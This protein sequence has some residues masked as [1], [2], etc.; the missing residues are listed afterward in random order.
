MSTSIFAPQRRIPPPS[1]AQRALRPRRKSVARFE[2]IEIQQW[3]K[4]W[5]IACCT[6]RSTTVGIPS[7]RV[8]P[9]ASVSP[10][11][12][13]AGARSS[14]QQCGHQFFD[15][16]PGSLHTALPPSSHRCPYAPL[17]A[18]AFV[19]PAQVLL[20][21]HPFHQIVRQG[22]ALGLACRDCLPL[23]ARLRLVP[24]SP[25]APWRVA[26]LRLDQA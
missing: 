6:I 23:L 14:V 2:D 10:P 12:S 9:P 3:L 19:R 26:P 21:T 5:R 22:S 15:V 7:W 17:L 18:H 25:L 1:V 16:F 24:A 8:P 20:L 11:L 4:T 13:P